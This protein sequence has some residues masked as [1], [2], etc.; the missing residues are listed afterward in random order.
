MNDE[1]AR[2]G[3]PDTYPIALDQPIGG[4]DVSVSGCAVCEL[5]REDWGE[6]VYFRNGIG[7]EACWL[8]WMKWPD[9]HKTFPAVGFGRWPDDDQ[10]PN[11]L[12]GLDD[13]LEVPFWETA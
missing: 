11:R 12:V 4:S 6:L 9:E 10:D 2:Q 7:F 13:A 1:A 3:R 5:R 8:C